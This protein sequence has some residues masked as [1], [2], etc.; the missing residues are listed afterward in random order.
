LRRQ[1]RKLNV[2]QISFKGIGIFQEPCRPTGIPAIPV[3]VVMLLVP[4]LGEDEETSDKK[5]Q[6]RRFFFLEGLFVFC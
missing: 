6:A 1:A 2:L 4:L 3:A 5:H